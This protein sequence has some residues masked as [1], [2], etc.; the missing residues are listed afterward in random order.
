VGGKAHLCSQS[1]PLSA[2][3]SHV[4]VSRLVL[5]GHI[6][7]KTPWDRKVGRIAAQHQRWGYRV[8]EQQHLSSA[9]QLAQKAWHE[10]MQK[11]LGLSCG[12]LIAGGHGGRKVLHEA[13]LMMEA[14]VCVK[15][16]ATERRY[17]DRTVVLHDRSSR[18]THRWQSR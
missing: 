11:M 15:L 1:L 12:P 13:R 4:R 14:S 16:S 3:Q 2:T 6:G 18:R 17:M 9:T 10:K 7:G 5:S 8:P